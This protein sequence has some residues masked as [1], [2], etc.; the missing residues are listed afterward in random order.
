MAHDTDFFVRQHYLDIAA[1]IVVREGK[2]RHSQKLH[3]IWS[4]MSSAIYSG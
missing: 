1:L 3:A 2:H 4:E